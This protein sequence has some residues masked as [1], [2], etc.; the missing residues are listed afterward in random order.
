[1]SI[2][3][4]RAEG[5]AVVAKRNAISIRPIRGG[6][7]KA[8][9]PSDLAI[10]VCETAVI[11]GDQGRLPPARPRDVY[12]RR[13]AVDFGQDALRN[14]PRGIPE[15]IPAL[16]DRVLGLLR[17][18]IVDKKEERAVGAMPVPTKDRRVSSQSSEQQS[19]LQAKPR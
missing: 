1:M 17:I 10:G 16:W 6:S 4:V 19:K 3:L 13:E 7:E 9:E 2:M 5:L 15:P 11:A 8:Q 12:S 14:C 18:I